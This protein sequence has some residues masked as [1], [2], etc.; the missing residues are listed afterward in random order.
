MKRNVIKIGGS[1]HVS[2][3]CELCEELN[4]EAGDK[5]NTEF[6]LLDENETEYS[7]KCEICQSE[8]ISVS[9]DRYCPTCGCEDVEK[10][11]KI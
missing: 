3:P 10:I 1:L 4:I 5:I 6:S 7:F 8:F 11:I 2:I 9:V